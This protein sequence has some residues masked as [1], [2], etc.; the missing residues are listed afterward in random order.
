[1]QTRIYAIYSKHRHKPIIKKIER[2]T[3]R[4]YEINRI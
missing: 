1:M 3:P 4:K 2:N